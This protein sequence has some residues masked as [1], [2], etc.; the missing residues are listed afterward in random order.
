MS[1]QRK[2]KNRY[3]V[4]YENTCTVMSEST[5]RK[6]KGTVINFIPEKKLD[7]DVANVRV[8]FSYNGSHY[9]S[10]VGQG[11]VFVTEGPS[12]TE[13]DNG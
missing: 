10:I 1:K 5:Q 11:M 3:N 8:N 7:V 12:F 6:V 4:R 2:Q 9:V 13:N